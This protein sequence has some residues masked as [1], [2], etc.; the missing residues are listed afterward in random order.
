[1]HENKAT[2]T[3]EI[4]AKLLK[5]SADEIV[6]PLTYLVNLSLTTGT[7]PS[8]WKKARICPIFKE[9]DST[10]PCNYRPI[11]ILPVLSKVI[12]RAVFDQMYPFLDG[13]VMIHDNQS[14]FRPN[15]STSSALLHITEEWLNAID[16]SKYIG[17]VMLDLKKAFDTVNHSI[18]LRKLCNYGLSLNVIEW[19]ESYL[20]DRKHVTTINGVKS[21]EEEIYMRY[22]TGINIRSTT[23]YFIYKRST[24]SCFECHS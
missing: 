4:P 9:G 14:G 18:L 2:G 24:K 17:I 13:K 19:F 11:S 3:D 7:F 15:F 23:F 5:I 16:E 20:E 6:L 10:E 21:E 8:Q 1:M 22:S 12:E